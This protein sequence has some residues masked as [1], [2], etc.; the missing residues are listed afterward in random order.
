MG[1]QYVTL[2]LLGVGLRP[3]KRVM[4]GDKLSFLS[5]DSSH[6]EDKAVAPKAFLALTE[7]LLRLVIKISTLKRLTFQILS[8]K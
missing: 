8:P 1:Q 3:I 2:T 6:S 4:I 7:S 5:C